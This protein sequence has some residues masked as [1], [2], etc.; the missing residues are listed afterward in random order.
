M[1]GG[2]V[3][4]WR[5]DEYEDDWHVP[6]EAEWYTLITALGGIGVAGGKMKEVGLDHWDS[7]NTGAT[8]S[9]FLTA[10]GT[11]WW[12]ATGSYPPFANAGQLTGFW[13]SAH[14]YFY[15]SD[16]YVNPEDVPYGTYIDGGSVYH[17]YYN[18]D[19]VTTYIYHGNCAFSIRCVRNV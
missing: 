5:N 14:W 9:S 7:P 11:G 12:P 18:N 1:D 13:T 19:N 8:N 4:F 10:L 16:G 17:C 2:I 6:S 15:S 3:A